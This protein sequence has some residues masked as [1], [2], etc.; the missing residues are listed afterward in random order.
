MMRL[1]L[2]AAALP[3][4]M[5]LAILPAFAGQTLDLRGT[6][7]TLRETSQPG[8]VAEVVMHNAEVNWPGDNGVYPLDMPG[9]SVDVAFR[10]D[11][12]EVGGADQITVTPPD[13]MTCEPETCVLTIPEGES[14]TLYLI[15]WV[16][17]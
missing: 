5:A 14:G 7:V 13:G 12:D 1:S 15:E 10:W 8:A 2:Y 16:G 4:A 11:A 9:L 3:C 17:M 6:T